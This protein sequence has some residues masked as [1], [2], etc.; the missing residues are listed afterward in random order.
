MDNLAV[1]Q[2]SG[3]PRRAAELKE[4]V[5]DLALKKA[6]DLEV[7][8]SQRFSG[9]S[10]KDSERRREATNVSSGGMVLGESAKADIEGAGVFG[11]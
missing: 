9:A 8:R 3:E 5:L 7:Q 4:N 6:V 11:H 2:D 10:S 1:S